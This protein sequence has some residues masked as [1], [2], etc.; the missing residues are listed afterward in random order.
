MMP[1]LDRWV[2]NHIAQ[3]LSV[4]PRA[5]SIFCLNVAR[6]TLSDHTFPGFIQ[7]QLQKLNIAASNLCFEV[8]TSD[9]ETNPADT[10]I[11]TQ[12][13]RELGCLV[14]LCSFSHSPGSLDLLDKMRMDYLKIDG[15]LI[16][17]ILRD[18]DD[19]EKV[20]TLNQL[21]HKAK[22]KTIAELVETDDIIAKLHEIGVDYAQGFGIAK[23]HPLKEL[24]L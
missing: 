8:E 2:V 20:T 23:P 14:S 17:N 16:C 5:D 15:S 9:A 21:A 22:I 19:L 4:H 13:I 24:E 10:L 6:D 11:F 12:K 1:Q 3:W 18:E 7:D